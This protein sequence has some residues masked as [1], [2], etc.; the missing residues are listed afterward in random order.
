VLSCGIEVAKFAC[1]LLFRVWSGTVW[2][3]LLSST[4]KSQGHL[5]VGTCLHDLEQ[6]RDNIFTVKYLKVVFTWRV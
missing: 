5:L 4:Y 2:A 6:M 1:S 3:Y